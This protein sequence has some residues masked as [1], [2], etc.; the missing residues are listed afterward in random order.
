MK[1]YPYVAIV[2]VNLNGYKLLKD[3]LVSLSHS[4]Y[5]NKYTG[6]FIV[7]NGSTD[8]SLEYIESLSNK[9]LF[10]NIYVIKNKINLGFAKANNL[11]F[12]QILKKRIYKYVV[13]LN[14]DTK[15]TKNWLPTLVNGMELHPDYAAAVGK[16]VK[17]DNP[18][19]VDSAGDMFNARTLRVVNRTT[20]KHSKNVY[21]QKTEVLSVCAAGAIF[22]AT[23]LKE[24]RIN[25]EYFD[26][27]F[28]SYI[29]DVDLNIRLRL[30]GWN[31]VYIPQALMFHKGSAT[32]SK[33]S[34]KYREFYSRRNRVLFAIKNFPPLLTFKL[35]I[36]YLFPTTKAYGFYTK[37]QKV[38]I[39]Q[40]K[41]QRLSLLDVCLVHLE[42]SIVQ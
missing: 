7:D 35:V 6:L 22:R 19:M 31:I 32:S 13:T 33:L 27:D 21:T 2:I 41:G 38:D 28:V 5:P 1:K 18:T 36:K 42:E 24:V 30:M 9:K 16:I 11:A 15:V 23:A 12:H 14:N 10:R 40:T 8:H 39:G 20:K 26:E 4:L 29:E 37:K 3:C 34:I 17:M 25:N